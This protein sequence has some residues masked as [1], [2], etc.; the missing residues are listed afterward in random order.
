[1]DLKKGQNLRTLQGGG[2]KKIEF[3]DSVIIEIELAYT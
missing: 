3:T 1:M 2:G